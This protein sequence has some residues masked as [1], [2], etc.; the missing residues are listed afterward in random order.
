[1]ASFIDQAH[2][3]N[4][5]VLAKDLRVHDRFLFDDQLLTVVEPPQIHRGLVEIWV[6]EWDTPFEATTSTH[7]SVLQDT[8]GA[9]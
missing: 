1:M 3:M 2:A 4:S 5:E 9:L 7:V 8:A 6:A